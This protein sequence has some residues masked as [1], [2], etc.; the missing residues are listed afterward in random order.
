MYAFHVQR[1]LNKREDL[2]TVKFQE[3]MSFLPEGMGS[4]YHDYFHRL[5]MELK[6]V[7]KRNP[8][9]FKI[10]E[11][12]VA[13]GKMEAELPLKFIARALDLALDCRET[14]RIIKKVNDAVSCL[15]YVSEDLTTVFHKSV[16]DWLVADGY[17]DHEYTVK[18][19]DGKK[20]LWLVCEQVFKEIKQ[21]VCLGHDLQLT[22]EV[23]HAL[24]YGH[25]YLLACDMKESFWWL[26]DMIIVHSLLDVYPKD[27]RY[28]CELLE[29]ASLRNDPALS[30]QLRQRISWHLTEMSYMVNQN[31]S[32]SSEFESTK[33]FSYLENVLEYSPKKC[34]TDDE[35]KIAELILAKSQ[36]WVKRISV[37]MK[38]LNPLVTN[39][40][41]CNIVAV[42][43]SSSKK[44]AAV[45]LSDGTICVLSLPNL[46]KFWQYST[47]CNSICCCTFAPDDTYILYGK[48]ETVIDTGK[49]KEVTFFNG[50]VEK[51][52]FCS[53]SPNGKRLLT[54]N[55]S[56]KLKIW[57]VVRRSLVAVLS[58][59]APV[60]SCRF[61]NTGLFI[62]GGTIF[63]K[64]DTYCVWN[65][66]T[67][68]RVD[69]R[70]RFSGN[71]RRN[72]DG[73]LRSERC[74]RCFRQEW[75]EIIPSKV[76]GITPPMQLNRH[77]SYKMGSL[78]DFKKLSSKM[79]TGIYR[80]V[81]CIFYLDKQESLRIIES[82]HFTTLAAWEI[83][84]G[85][86]VLG[87]LMQDIP[88]VDFAAIEDNHWLYSDD[89]KLV[90]FSSV[91][92]TENQPSL[93]RPACVLWCSFSP[94]GTR[95]ATCISDG[96]I[97]L[98]NVH[99]SQI[100]QRFRSS[101]ETSSA[102]CWWSDK[103]LL[104]CHVTD[105]IPSL[106]RFPTDGSLKVITNKR[107]QLPLCSMSDAFLPFSGFLD[108]SEGYLS[109]ECGRAEPVKVFDVKK[110][111]HPKKIILPGI[112]PMMAIAISRRAS[113]IL[114]ARKGYF[115]WKK[116]KSQPTVYYVFVKFLRGPSP[117]GSVFTS[118]AYECC[119][120][121]DS[122][123][124]FV[125]SST[126][127][128]RSFVVIDVDT[129]STTSDEIQD[130]PTSASTCE[131]TKIFCT[132][133]VVIRLTPN[134]IEIFDLRTWK[135]LE[136]SFQRYLSRCFVNHSK[137][138]PKG[139]ILA[140]PRLTGDV[141][142]FKLCIPKHYSVLNS[143]NYS[144]RVGDAKSSMSPEPD[145]F[146]DIS[147][148]KQDLKET[149]PGPGTFGNI[150]RG[151]SDVKETSPVS[152]KFENIPKIRKKVKE[153]ATESSRFGNMT[154]SKK[155][156]KDTLSG[157]GRFGNIPAIEKN[158]KEILPGPGRFGNIP[159][160]KRNAKEILPG[161]GRFGNIPAIEKT[162]RKILSGS[163]RF[164]NIPA[165]EKNVKEI[166][167]GP[168]RFGNI[169]TIKRNAKET[170]PGPGRFG[171]IPTIKKTVKEILPG[172][173]RFGDVSKI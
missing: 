118:F 35:R 97:N 57:D 63:K 56:D 81:D 34:F 24:R 96:F 62:V 39:T 16:Y 142:F 26:V 139:T 159:T 61:T 165:I 74:N 54:N 143:Q 10:L 37:G 140:V 31:I 4:V 89:Q 8:D 13:I 117:F 18:V 99:T 25:E 138:S 151:K 144:K 29:R 23:K 162:V 20:R 107:Q 167:P 43:V 116:N 154:T 153:T 42:G 111:R 72:K 128:D 121:N 28:L 123:F 106:L 108:F 148:V 146:K 91:P 84:M 134:L 102:V 3:I 127:L 137:L 110:V 90:V 93:P 124:A 131:V 75:K 65:S 136:F 11:L 59:G 17:D 125:S 77:L 157:P 73:V 113:F 122:K 79:C 7:M 68:E 130:S 101:R 27:T 6:V 105:T 156:A 104:V 92:P 120:S 51:F 145:I 109:F 45:A 1:E 82:I 55:G 126:M 149:S 9:L 64:E 66:I 32:T 70:T 49:R 2:D 141:E 95:L 71:E 94:D 67:L 48:L 163:G 15:L 152:D 69:Q 169:P 58:A 44:L 133:T 47:E 114:A 135:R 173:G 132:G 85:S 50:E 160:I 21:A 41:S 129:G 166:L 76:L 155:N 86:D 103:Y 12:L 46:I 33:P 38:S 30:I 80:E 98:W 19:S 100:Y 158:V 40:F 172:P 161:P 112:K 168:G 171:N 170:L 119:F 22:N 115:L 83:F 52:K 5:E 78:F 150:L 53:F 36:R 60:D 164:G 87:F 88:F 14:K 147:N